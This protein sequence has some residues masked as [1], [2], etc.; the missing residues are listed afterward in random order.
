[1]LQH[2]YC[3]NVVL[4]YDVFTVVVKKE[5]KMKKVM[6]IVIMAMSFYACAGVI[7]PPPTFDWAQG[8]GL[9]NNGTH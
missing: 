1:M 8:V 5:M 7:G 9:D 2:S 4:G 6:F 3:V